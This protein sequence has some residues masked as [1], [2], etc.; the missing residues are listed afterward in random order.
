MECEEARLKAQ[1]LA[2]NEL[3]EKEIP[4]VL[5]HLES[6]YRCRNEYIGFV[7]LQKQLKGASYPRPG[8]EWFEERYK[9]RSRKAGSAIGQVFFI[10]S[11]IALI[12][13]AVTEVFRDPEVSLFPRILT[14][15][16]ILGI[17]VLFAVTLGDRIREKKTDRYG[18]VQ[19]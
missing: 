13:F 19:K 15:G 6:C 3:D 4:E 10:V 16:I 7:S 1:A 18:D 12:V 2:D 9:K 14:G 11:Y 8:E 5:H 17:I